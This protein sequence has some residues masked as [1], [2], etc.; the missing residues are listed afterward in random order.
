ML[1]VVAAPTPPARATPAHRRTP[2]AIT[3]SGLAML[4]ITYGA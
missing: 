4:K 2:I 1:R 3:N